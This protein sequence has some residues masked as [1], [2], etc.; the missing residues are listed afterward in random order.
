[1]GNFVISSS[2]GEI[3]ILAV[4]LWLYLKSTKGITFGGK[5]GMIIFAVFLVMMQMASLFMLPPP[6]IRGFAI[7]GL[8]YQLMMVGVVSWLDRKRI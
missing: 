1:M 6:D 8:V 2:L 7:F 3:L 4:G 5:Y